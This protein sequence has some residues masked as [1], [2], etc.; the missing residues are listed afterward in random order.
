MKLLTTILVFTALL[1]EYDKVYVRNYY[2]VTTILTLKPD[3][4][5]TIKTETHRGH[6]CTKAGR[7]TYTDDTL[8]L[9]MSTMTYFFEQTI[10]TCYIYKYHM[11]ND[12][13]LAEVY[14]PSADT[15]LSVIFAKMN[16]VVP[17]FNLVTEK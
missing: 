2:P 12:T 1:N 7:Y 13:T 8:V 9:K 6:Q 16:T 14:K 3:T 15:S 17:P 5:F 10:D 11:V 4:T